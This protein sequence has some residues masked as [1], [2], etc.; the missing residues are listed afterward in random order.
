MIKEP[1]RYN[2]HHI[3]NQPRQVPIHS[4]ESKSNH[5]NH[6]CTTFHNDKLFHQMVHKN[7]NTNRN[8]YRPIHLDNKATRFFLQLWDAKQVYRNLFLSRFRMA[9]VKCKNIHQPYLNSLCSHQ[10]LPINQKLLRLLPLLTFS[11]L[12]PLFITTFIQRL[13]Q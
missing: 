2:H 9:R 5:N 11:W 8:L 7:S 12:T 10:H 1:N 3:S 13:C 4:Q 6:H